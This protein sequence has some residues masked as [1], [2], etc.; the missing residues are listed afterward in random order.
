MIAFIIAFRHP[1]STKNYE[2]VVDLLR[3]TLLSLASQTNENY[4]VYI[5]CNVA[6]EIDI[7]TNKVRICTIDCPIPSS[8]KEVLLD[9][10]VKRALAIQTANNEIKPD[11][12]FLL[13]ADDLVSTDC[14][15]YLHQQDW[16]SSPGGYWLER[17]FLLDM[18]N[19]KV[20]EKYGFNR[21]CGSSLILSATTLTS[22]LF[23]GESVDEK[24]S[25]HQEFLTACDE[26]ILEQV[27]GDHIA[28]RG[29][30]ASQEQ[31]LQKILRPLTCWKINTG[32]N[33]SSTKIPFG[34]RNIDEAFL[35]RFS[36]TSI[37]TRRASVFERMV[38]KFR[39]LKSWIA[40]ISK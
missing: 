22:K 8:R 4:R 13:D 16:A 32:E 9:K 33:E 14:V 11:Y 34:S 26:Y 17:G 2:H 15:D 30:M 31:P 19:R 39:L 1:N 7:D 40:S 29:F 20:Q 24:M 18:F 6:P 36:I 37:D 3:A 27:L 10:G 38:E 35:K 21:Y 5:G 28:V 25:T 23:T 12:F